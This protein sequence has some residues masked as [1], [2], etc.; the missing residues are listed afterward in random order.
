MYIYNVTTNVA[1]A[2]HK[3]WLQWMKEVYVPEMLATG[4]FTGGKMSRVMVQEEMGGM[5]YSVQ[6]AVKDRETFKAFYIEDASRMNAIMQSKFENGQVV[7]FQ[8]ELEVIGD[9]Y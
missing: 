3:D 2:I 6:Y 4:K 7:S 5:T 9:F 1:E 8:T